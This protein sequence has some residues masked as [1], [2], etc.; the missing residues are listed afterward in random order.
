MVSVLVVDDDTSALLIVEAILQQDGH[1][2]AFATDGRLGIR[3]FKEVNPALAIID[4]FMPNQEGLQTI[5]ELRALAPTLPIIAMSGGSRWEI[6]DFLTM[7][8]KLGA[9]EILRKP[10]DRRV[11]RDMVRRLLRVGALETL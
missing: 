10:F 6:A 8:I 2:V 7:S 4:I 5:I 3:T 9:S 11:L 1:Q